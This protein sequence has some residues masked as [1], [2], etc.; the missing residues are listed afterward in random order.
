MVYSKAKCV[1]LST[2]PF[3]LSC[4]ANGGP[5]KN[6]PP[7]NARILATERNAN[8]PSVISHPEKFRM[9]YMNYEKRDL[10]P[11]QSYLISLYL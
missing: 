10:S 8:N 3:L 5:F 2:M 9:E 11:W 4:N 1:S 7:E 6:S